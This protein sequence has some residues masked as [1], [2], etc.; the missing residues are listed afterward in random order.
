MLNVAALFL[1]DEGSCRGRQV[2]GQNA[3]EEAPGDV[4]R[5]E[6]AVSERMTAHWAERRKKA[7]KK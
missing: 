7:A 6:K 4:G 1:A 5:G 3:G 2:R